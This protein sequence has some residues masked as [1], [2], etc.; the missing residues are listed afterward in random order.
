MK[1]RNIVKGAS[2][3]CDRVSPYEGIIYVDEDKGNWIKV[4]ANDNLRI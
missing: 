4:T 1:M 3:G 2:K